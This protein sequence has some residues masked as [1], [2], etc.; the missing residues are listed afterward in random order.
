MSVA[1]AEPT[2]RAERGPY[3]AAVRD[4]A[5]TSG[6]AW[7]RWPHMTRDVHIER[8]LSWLPLALSE[9]PFIDW[10][11]VPSDA[12]GHLVR[13]D[14][15]A[16][17]VG[18]IAFAL[19]VSIGARRDHGLYTLLTHLKMLLHHLRATPVDRAFDLA[20][21]LFWDAIVATMPHT[22]GLMRY[23]LDYNAIAAGPMRDYLERVK[24]V[25]PDQY[26]R[27]ARYAF[28]PL[29]YSITERLS[30][31]R[32]AFRLE[33]QVRRKASSDMLVPLYPVLL[34]IVRHRVNVARRMIDQIHAAGEAVRA[35]GALLPYAFAYEDTIPEHNPDA[36]SIG[37]VRITGRPVTMRF[38]LWDRVSWVLHHQETGNAHTIRVARGRRRSYSP[39]AAGHRMFVEFL[40]PVDDLL[41]FGDLIE[42]RLLRRRADVIGPHEPTTAEARRHKTLLRQFG[43]ANGIGCSRPGLLA[44]AR[45]DAVW[46][47]TY[48]PGHLLFEPESLY[49]GVLY[50]ATVATMAL[51]GA[52]RVAEILQ[53]SE[54]RKM[55]RV[56]T[57]AVVGAD[58]TP[59][60]GADGQPVRRRVEIFLQHLLPKGRRTDAE[61]QLFCLSRETVR[62]LSEIRRDL[63]ASHGVVPVVN[64]PHVSQREH[65][66]QERYLLQWAATPDGTKG[67]LT[68]DDAQMLLRFILHGVEMRT[69]TGAPILPTVHLLR[70]VTGTAA[71]H[72]R[73][74]PPEAVAFM[75]HHSQPAD[76]RGAGPVALNAATAYYTQMPERD[77]V[78]LIHDFQ[79]EVEAMAG[80]LDLFPPTERD[81]AAMDDGLR[82]AFETWQTLHPTAF[83]YCMC[84]TLCPRGLM[85]SLCLGCPY[86]HPDPREI[87]KALSWRDD[88]ARL[89]AKLEA[90]GNEIDARQARLQV[91]DLDT[92]IHLMR[93][94]AQGERDGAYTPAFKRLPMTTMHTGHG[95]G[96]ANG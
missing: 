81:L 23:Y 58:G 38:A 75:L 63:I 37:E 68:P 45:D 77:R 17:D 95:G 48:Q 71:R 42:N 50:G 52:A 26:E 62:L 41:W 92:L 96:S 10:T 6:A 49:R 2:G 7:E 82:A 32:D 66:C 79:S 87:A 86:L 27:V 33:A 29:P 8:F 80:A 21:P 61:R 93:L 22:H 65:L 39:A 25:A 90:Q 84:P 53:V 16:P 43:A 18:M 78:L 15:T 55:R 9:A 89:A 56:E 47:R 67:A 83:G 13:L 24:R 5:E 20:D 54:D 44:P 76:A 88:Y 69:A 73:G 57:V 40:G 94:M 28:P 91:A 36:T 60:V 12:M 11:R 72:L 74:V 59:L 4:D 19:G 70:H 85:R 14:N 31:M 30:R 3:G 35:T 34:A 51:T 1:R 46:L 64:P